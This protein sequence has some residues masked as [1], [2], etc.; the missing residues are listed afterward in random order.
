M[1][2]RSLP[3]CQQRRDILGEKNSNLR[4][5]KCSQKEI[6][7]EFEQFWIS[8]ELEKCKIEKSCAVSGR[9]SC[10]RVLGTS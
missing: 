1:H 4:T 8:L 7:S 3:K 9:V 10:W 6:R 5:W 2:S